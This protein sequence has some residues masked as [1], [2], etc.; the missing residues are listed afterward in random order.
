MSNSRENPKFSL[1]WRSLHRFPESNGTWQLWRSGVICD[2]DESTVRK[3]ARRWYVAQRT[4]VSTPN[5]VKFLPLICAPDLAELTHQSFLKRYRLIFYLLGAYFLLTLGLTLTARDPSRF[6]NVL[7]FLTISILY[8]WAEYRWVLC[9][10]KALSER[11][12]FLQTQ[13][14][15]KSPLL[16]G[17]LVIVAL[18]G[19]AQ[20]IYT[21]WFGDLESLVI[22]F[23][24]YYPQ[25]DAGQWWRYVTG[26][27]LHS[28][29]L[30]WLVNLGL[31]TALVRII[32]G[33]ADAR[34]LLLVLLSLPMSAAAAHQLNVNDSI[35]GFVGI[36][37]GVFCLFG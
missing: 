12:L 3:L 35:E 20:F 27:F 4:L 7:L 11:A 13:L 34:L 5:S 1:D 22:S 16:I 29:P 15:Q 28:S 21:S 36:S 32:A 6:F 30:H 2:A 33:L 24:T 25:I 23:G 19:I 37:G 10:Y 18:I 14:L 9:S 17:L 8:L 31:L 26:P